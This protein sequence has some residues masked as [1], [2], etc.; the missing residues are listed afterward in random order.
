LGIR[1]KGGSTKVIEIPKI[2][3]SLHMVDTEKAIA[4]EIRSL[5][6]LGHTYLEIIDALNE[7]DIKNAFTGKQ[8]SV[9]GIRSLMKRHDVPSRIE[10]A[11]SDHAEVWLTAKEKIAE[12]GV[13]NAK[14]RRMR[15][16]GEL[17]FKLPSNPESKRYL[18]K[19]VNRER[20]IATDMLAT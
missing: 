16:A 10:L 18:Y 7:K 6:S 4:A 13:S 1:F 15:D 17:V 12:L 11:Q 8:F 3:R 14:F 2:A 20:E 19:S 5:R 9:F